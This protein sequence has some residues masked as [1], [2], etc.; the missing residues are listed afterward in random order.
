LLNNGD[1]P[2]EATALSRPFSV[3]EK[4]G[5]NVVGFKALNLDELAL[6][7]SAD[8]QNQFDDLQIVFE[9]NRGIVTVW[10]NDEKK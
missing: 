6:I 5:I 1:P 3:N 7:Y 8:F 2:L 10:L 4:R 9:N